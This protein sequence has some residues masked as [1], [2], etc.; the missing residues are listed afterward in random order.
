[1]FSHSFI[2]RGVLF[3]RN[4]TPLSINKCGKCRMV[5]LKHLLCITKTRRAKKNHVATP[6]IQKEQNH[7]LQGLQ[8]QIVEDC[9]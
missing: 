9:Q 7:I 8:G 3:S 6:L 4:N 5:K 2:L 1:M